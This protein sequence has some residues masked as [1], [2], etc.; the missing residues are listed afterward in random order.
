MEHSKEVVPAELP[1]SFSIKGEKVSVTTDWKGSPEFQKQN[2]VKGTFELKQKVCDISKES[3]IQKTVQT[4]R[5]LNSVKAAFSKLNRNQKKAIMVEWFK[6]DIQELLKLDKKTFAKEKY[7][8]LAKKLREKINSNKELE[9][10]FEIFL[11]EDPKDCPL[12]MGAL[13]LKGFDGFKKVPY[14]DF[15]KVY[16]ERMKKAKEE[17]KK[18]LIRWIRKQKLIIQIKDGSQDL[19]D[20]KKVKIKLEE[21]K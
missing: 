10:K 15:G 21:N 3:E 17:Q 19:F 4:I 6:G 1:F 18:A 9:K 11:N 13:K 12:T 8:S 14:K 5:N 7:D 20:L 2:L 16:E